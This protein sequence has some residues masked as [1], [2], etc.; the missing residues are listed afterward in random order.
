MLFPK[1]KTFANYSVNSNKSKRTFF[2][3]ERATKTENAQKQ[4]CGGTLATKLN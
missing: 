1:K 2:K 3:N 4:D